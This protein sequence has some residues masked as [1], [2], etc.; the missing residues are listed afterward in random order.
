[1]ATANTQVTAYL[2]DHLLDY[3]TEYCTQYGIVRKK[4]SKPLLA[5]GIVDLLSIVSTIPIEDLTKFTP[6]T[7]KEDT[8][9]K[10]LTDSKVVSKILDTLLGNEELRQRLQTALIP[11]DFLK[12][13]KTLLSTL[14][15]NLLITEDEDND[16]LPSNVPDTLPSSKEEVR[17][18]DLNPYIKSLEGAIEVSSQEVEEE[19]KPIVEDVEGISPKP[20][21]NGKNEQITE[22][23]EDIKPKR[24]TKKVKVNEN[25]LTDKQQLVMDKIPSLENGVYSYL[26]LARALGTNRT[27][28]GNFDQWRQYFTFNEEKKTYTKL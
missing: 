14:P 23:V 26:G 22:V 9:E 18:D 2:P 21:D 13:D 1:M 17:K 15:N 28:L 20:V 10:K 4:D 16:N 24:K 3:V 25:G 6:Q 11:D 27:V 7:I 19:I 8:L 12:E 5:T